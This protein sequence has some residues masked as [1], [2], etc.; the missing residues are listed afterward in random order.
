M[1]RIIYI[2]NFLLQHGFAPTT[3]YALVPL[4]QKEGCEVI[5]ASNKKN[6]LQ[7]LLHMLSTIITH[8]KNAIV[9]IATYSTTAFYFAYSCS[10]VCRLLQLPYVPCLHGGNLPQRIASSPRLSQQYF[11]RS[12]INVAVS[13]YLQQA[14]LAKNWTCT[15]IPNAIPVSLYACRLRTAARPNLLWVRSFHKLYNPQMAVHVLAQLRKRY[16]NAT[17]TMV[18][19]DKDGSLADCIYLAK[20]GGLEAAVNFTGKLTKEAW[21][22]L[23]ATHDIF[24]NTTTADNLP[25]SVIEAMA[26][27]M[28]VISTNAGGMPYLIT[29]GV[30][31]L[32]CKTN[33]VQDMVNKIES[34]CN[35]AQLA[36]VLSAN[37]HAASGQYDE[38]VVMQQWKQ[39]LTR[40]S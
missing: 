14:V 24:I 36:Q 17:L 9:L 31:G 19:P 5:A 11:G 3:G 10:L 37:A 32:L 21:T 15:V 8:R 6:Q 23:A 18:G 20:T 26:L 34:I 30:N 27:G 28:I 12:I 13:G 7:R 33:D 25:V 1:K 39:L 4:L 16:N 38:Q 40:L 22:A 29:N 2:D 35:N